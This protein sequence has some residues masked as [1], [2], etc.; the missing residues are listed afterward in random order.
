MTSISTTTTTT[1]LVPQT[2][3]K[4]SMILIVQTNRRKRDAD[5][6]LLRL[7]QW[8]VG[9]NLLLVLMLLLCVSVPLMNI[10]RV[11]QIKCLNITISSLMNII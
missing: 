3:D 10:V 7:L 6:V 1:T 8:R 5:E 2:V 11:H 4:L 9:H